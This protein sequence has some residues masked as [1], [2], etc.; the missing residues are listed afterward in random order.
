VNISL[1][2]GI[3]LPRTCIISNTQLTI[4]TI[5]ELQSQEQQQLFLSTDSAPNKTADPAPSQFS[6]R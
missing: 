5:Q 4:P 2:S 3:F 6:R 1:N